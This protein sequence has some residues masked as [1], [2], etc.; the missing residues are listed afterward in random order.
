MEVCCICNLFNANAI[1][2]FLRQEV[3]GEAL[4]DADEF[5]G[6][7]NKLEDFFAEAPAN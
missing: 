7:A 2:V 3:K 1:T 4:G 6:V 5:N